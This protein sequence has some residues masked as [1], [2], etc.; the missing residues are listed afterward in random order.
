MFSWELW[1][2]F[3][4]MKNVFFFSLFISGKARRLRQAKEEAQVE[5]ENFRAEYE[6]KYK[7]YEN[8]VSLLPFLYLS[9]STFSFSRLFNIFKYNKLYIKFNIG[10]PKKIFFSFLKKQ[11]KKKK[12]TLN[13][14]WK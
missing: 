5:I 9:S 1:K 12:A 2:L 4:K 14:S 3:L 11:K 6:T 13:S 10:M 8:R 7:E